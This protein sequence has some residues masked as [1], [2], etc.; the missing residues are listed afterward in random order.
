MDLDTGQPSDTQNRTH[1][2]GSA[3]HLRK[4]SLPIDRLIDPWSLCVRVLKKRLSILINQSPIRWYL[5]CTCAYRVARPLGF[6]ASTLAASPVL[7]PSPSSS[8]SQ[9][10]VRP[11]VVFQASLAGRLCPRPLRDSWKF[12]VRLNSQLSTRPCSELP[13]Q[14]LVF[15]NCRSL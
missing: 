15:G 12:E 13:T 9:P 4:C 11:V 14:H 1:K 10:P 2:R 3:A 5:T 7:A 6:C 8:C